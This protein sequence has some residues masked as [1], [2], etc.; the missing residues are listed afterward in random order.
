M[1]SVRWFGNAWVTGK[2]FSFAY[3]NR[4][5]IHGDVHIIR[6]SDEH[7]GIKLLKKAREKKLSIAI[8]GLE[9]RCNAF[10]TCRW[11]NLL[12]HPAEHCIS[13]AEY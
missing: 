2:V 4:T 13:S 8:V 5:A 10:T 9:K 3:T 7:C 11:C 6:F 1:I 12:K